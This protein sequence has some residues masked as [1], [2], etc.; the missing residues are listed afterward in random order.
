MILVVDDDATQRRTIGALLTASSKAWCGVG[1]GP[2]AL[3][4]LRGE[5]GKGIALVLLDLAMPV[6]TGIEVLKTLRPDFPD[7]PVLMLTSNGSVSNAVSAM[8]AGATDF[9]IKPI[10]SERLEVSIANAL[11]IRSLT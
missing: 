9:L 1:S 6:M 7:L 2:D 3:D 10:S 4:L 5:E 8:Q 11:K